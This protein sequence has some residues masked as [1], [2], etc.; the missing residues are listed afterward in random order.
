[1][2]IMPDYC[3]ACTIGHKIHNGTKWFEFEKGVVTKVKMSVQYMSLY[4]RAQ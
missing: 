1:M 2:I 4:V 3:V